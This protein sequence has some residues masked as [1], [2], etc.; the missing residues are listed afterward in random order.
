MKALIKKQR[1]IGHMV[2]EDVPVPQIRPNEVLVRVNCVG[3]CGT[4]LKIYDDTF[5]S[6]VPV[7]VGHE[8]AGDIVAVGEQ[9]SS[10]KVGMRVVSEQHW[11][12]CGVCEYCLSGRRHLC[13]HK[14]SPGYLSDGAYAEFIAVEQSL[15]HLIHDGLDYASACL[16]EPMGVAAHAL[17]EK[18]RVNPA[19]KVVILGCGPI[20]LMTLQILKAIGAGWIGLT[21]L[22]SDEA[23]RFPL[24]L[25]FGADRVINVERE[26]AE[27]IVKAATNGL[28]ADVVIDLTGSAKAIVDAFRFIKRDGRFCA[29]GLPHGDISIPWSDL[30]LK[31]IQ[32]YFSF[33]SGHATWEKCMWLVGSGKVDLAPFTEAV[34]PLER[35]MQAFED[36]RQGKVLKAIIRIG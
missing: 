19:D 33:S 4:D 11:H 26:S 3:V 34:Y 30:V 9:V 1:G 36:A 31:A 24:A 29:I 10:L 20:A 32:I 21:G 17:F 8:F 13:M 22:T 15:I 5:Y 18:C 35:W 16:L 23:A 14:R 28:G 25:R 7:I 27:S 6:D 12:A 2:I